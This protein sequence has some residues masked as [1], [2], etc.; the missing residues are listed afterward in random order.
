MPPIQDHL[1][2]KQ[3]LL[4]AAISMAI[5]GTVYASAGKV[6]F[7][8][9]EVTATSV[10]G[11]S[12]KLT[13][14][15]VINS[16]DTI[17]TGK[18]GIAQL[19]FTDGAYVSLQKNS[20]FRVDEYNY[21]G[22]TDGQEKGFFSLL[23]GGFRTITGLIGKG[24]RDRYQVRTAVATIGIRGT[25]Y[26]AELG[27]SITITVTEGG[28][29]ICNNAGCNIL[30]E[31]ETGY[32]KNIDSIIQK[33]KDQGITVT[34]TEQA[35]ETVYTIGDDTNPTGET[36]IPIP[37]PACGMQRA[38]ISNCLP[39]RRK[40]LLIETARISPR[41]FLRQDTMPFPSCGIP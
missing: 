3:Q 1:P 39:F 31:G 29:E 40:D 10:S 26:I 17:E 30:R 38:Y 41:P 11:E 13:K 4:A 19:R 35:G 25:E 36:A 37:G 33:L 8:F 22:K 24:Q 23:K 27:N 20:T 18:N 2:S 28:I 34:T 15:G 5:Q 21:N 32:I 12:R 14:D 6:N 9:G 16:G 7:A